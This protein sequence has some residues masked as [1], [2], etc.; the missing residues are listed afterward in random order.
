ME[1]IFRGAKSQQKTLEM[2]ISTSKTEKTLKNLMLL[3]LAPQPGLEPGTY[4]LT[5]NQAPEIPI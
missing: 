4:R 3:E 1:S 5:G 2:T